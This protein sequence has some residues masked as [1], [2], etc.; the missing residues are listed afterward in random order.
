MN[1]FCLTFLGMSGAV[2]KIFA[3]IA[4][5]AVFVRAKLIDKDQIKSVSSLIV[6]ILLPCLTFSKIITGLNTDEFTFWWTIPLI[7]LFITTTGML[8]AYFALSYRDN[9]NRDLIVTSTVQNFSYLVLPIGQVLYPDSFD[10]FALYVFLLAL[11]MNPFLWSF[12]KY[13]LIG[14]VDNGNNDSCEKKICDKSIGNKNKIKSIFDKAYCSIS[15]SNLKKIITPPFITNIIAVLFV[16]TGINNFVPDTL[17]ESM[18]FVGSGA[19]PVATIL[20]GATLGGISINHIPSIKDLVKC[21]VVKFIVM[22]LLTIAFIVTT[23]LNINYPLLADFF[24]I[25]A[26]AAPATG[27]ILQVRKYNGDYEKIEAIMFVMYIVAIIAM[28]FWLAIWKSI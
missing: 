12:G 1:T 28:P 23:K 21:N 3:I 15:N 19:I 27:I 10:K 14:N 5:G 26:S 18:A 22:P 24:V 17:V 11:G 6:N 9:K 25:Q 20:L 8:I 7:G 2:I 16:L 13:L 4:M